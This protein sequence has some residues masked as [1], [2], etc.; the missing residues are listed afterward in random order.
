[1]KTGTEQVLL[2]HTLQLIGPQTYSY[3]AAIDIRA[4]WEKCLREAE[5]NLT[6]L[7]PEGYSVRIR[8]AE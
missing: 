3:L 5:E 7:L 6:D 2:T 1:M 4:S 8:E